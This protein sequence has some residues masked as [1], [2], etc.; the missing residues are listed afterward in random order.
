[1]NQRRSLLASAVYNPEYIA[2]VRNNIAPLPY[3]TE[4]AAFVHN[5]TTVA[6][7]AAEER[8]EVALVTQTSVSRCGAT[9]LRL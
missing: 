9:R 2:W 1:M 8:P 5:W 7:R 4:H 6:E 3:D